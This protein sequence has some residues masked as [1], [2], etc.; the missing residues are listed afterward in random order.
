MSKTTVRVIIEKDMPSP[1]MMASTRALADAL[2]M[3]VSYITRVK[4]NSI[5][6]SEKQYQRFMRKALDINSS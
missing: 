5:R 4:N 6:L 1:F 2:G 3:S